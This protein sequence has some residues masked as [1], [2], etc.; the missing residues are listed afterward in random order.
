MCFKQAA[1]IAS[2]LKKGE[3][4]LF[5]I[6]SGTFYVILFQNTKHGIE[7]NLTTNIASHNKENTDLKIV[8]GQDMFM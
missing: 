1:E 3:I 2:C 8:I 4:S 7:S 5:K 6:Y